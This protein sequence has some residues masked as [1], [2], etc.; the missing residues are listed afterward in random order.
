MLLLMMLLLMMMEEAEDEEE[1]EEE[2]AGW[3]KKN[4]NPT[5]QCDNVGKKVKQERSVKPKKPQKAKN[6]GGAGHCWTC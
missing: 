6:T 5:W 3:S 4:T 1:E 2:A